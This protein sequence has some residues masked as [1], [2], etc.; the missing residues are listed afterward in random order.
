MKSTNDAGT[1]ALLQQLLA[2][3]ASNDRAAL[4][5]LVNAAQP[6]ADANVLLGALGNALTRATIVPP[7]VVLSIPGYER[8]AEDVVRH[9]AGF[10]ELGQMRRK[11]HTDSR[12]WQCIDTE[13]EGRDV[14]VIG[15]WINDRD[16][17]ETY[18]TAY[19]VVHWKAK[20]L[21]IV[22]AHHGDARQERAQEKGESVDALF[23]SHMFTSIPPASGRQNE[24]VLV[25]IHADAVLGF[26][27]GAGMCATNVPALSHMIDKIVQSEF[28]GKCRLASPDA[29][30]AKIVQKKGEQLGLGTAVANK[31]RKG[32]KTKTYGFLGNVRGWD[33][34]LSDD[35][36][37]SF[38]SA[39]GAG[40]LMRKKGARRQILACAHL[41]APVNPA[42][43][44]SYVRDVYES[45]VFDR[46]YVM[47]TLPHA[48]ELQ[49]KYPN[50]LIVERLGPM[51]VP[52]LLG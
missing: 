5:K 44:E 16:L 52:Y 31:D 50:F 13:L 41:V 7:I 6:G 42:H 32:G 36:A 24:V 45:G 20:K 39:I 19:N 25:D 47:D 17:M 4:Y 33:V 28:N 26:F 23:A 34:L 15:G 10:F 9:G 8:I 2:A 38:G 51:L 18:R 11:N 21:T 3:A 29:G 14:V 40:E 49:E 27:Q 22:I 46:L 1:N 37:V 43:G 35:L 12:P 48:Y 30:R